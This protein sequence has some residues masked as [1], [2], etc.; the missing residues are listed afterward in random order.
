MSDTQ[1]LIYA[2]DA[3]QWDRC[4][5][6]AWFLFH[7]LAGPPLK[8]DHFGQ[9][10]K[11]L[12]EEHE[13]AILST[14]INPVTASSPEHT[15][16]LIDDLVP[17]IYQP[18]FIDESLGLVGN[19]DFLILSDEGYQVA[20]AKL[21]M[22]VDKNRAIKT[23]LGIYQRLSNT[24]L[25]PIVFLGDGE[26]YEV[27]DDIHAL[28][29]R[30]LKDMAN[31]AKQKEL[32]A[33]HFGFSKCQGCAFYDYCLPEFEQQDDLTL[34][35]AIDARTAEQLRLQ[36][37][38]TLSEVA[39]A[40]PEDITEA[41]YL[42]SSEKRQRLIAQA[43]SLKTGKPMTRLVGEWP[44]GTMI[45]FDVESD[46]LAA[47]GA[48]EVYLWGLLGPPY[49]NESYDAVW[50]DTDDLATWQGFLN[51]VQR[52][53]DRYPDLL[54]VHYS[55]YERV[56]IEH[57]AARY[58]AINEPTVQW[59]LDENGPLWDLQKFLKS[60]FI[61]PVYSYGL[62]AI[63]KDQRLANFQWR[64]EESGSQWSVVRYYDYVQAMAQGKIAEAADI[65]AE[66]L[67]YNEDDVRATAA[68][69]DWL[70]TLNP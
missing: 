39:S 57:Y 51:T 34:S 55:P 22:S 68:V 33:T 2:S 41:P 20:D 13:A 42:R 44:K 48:G 4:I 62:K 45:H 31:V 47:D 67:L 6:L 12:G 54:L 19:P 23:Q 38:N 16:A 9:L 24:S 63:C 65:R 1:R 52:Y 10:I 21:A 15:Q 14:F 18:Q 58:H 27:G 40:L 46:P 25:A 66:I 11:T 35:P 8:D 49:T 56:Q 69:V 7:P 70:Q 5:R 32:P 26:A 3:H 61:L 50:R 64:M 59:L 53:K 17:V 37:F 36:G 28:A 60:N 29:T 30:F 43:E